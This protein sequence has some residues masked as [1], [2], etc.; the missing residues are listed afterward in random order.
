MMLDQQLRG[1]HQQQNWCCRLLNVQ[2]VSSSHAKIMQI[3]KLALDFDVSQG[4]TPARTAGF[5]G[6]V[7]FSLT[8][9]QGKG[10]ALVAIRTKYGFEMCI[11]ECSH[12]RGGAT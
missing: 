5:P 4:L 12:T 7:S 3:F 9:R 8:L 2:Y 10:T 1:I 6:I 11:V